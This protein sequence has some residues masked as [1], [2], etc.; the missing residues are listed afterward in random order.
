MGP[1]KGIKVVEIAGIGPAPVAGMLLADLGAEVILVER[2]TGNPNAISPAAARMGK[3]AFF[4]RGK[5][6]IALDLKMPEALELVL[7][8]V[9][10]ADVLIEGFRPGV[11]ERLG[12]GP[13]TCFEKNARLVYGRMTGWGQ[14]GP[15][16]QSAGHDLN[17]ASLSGALHY[18][19]LPGD[20]PFP[21]AT[22]LG[23]VAGGAMH[24]ALGVVSA[25]LH[26]QR[27]GEG[28]I[29]DAAVCDG[30]AYMMTLFAS[31]YAQGIIGDERG[32]DFFT[33]GAH[34]CNT[35]MCADQRY[36]T[37]EALEP[38]FYRQLISLC[39][40][41]DDPDFAEQHRKASWPAA[42][43]KMSRLFASK[44]Q[45]EWSSLLE[46]TDSCFAP[47]LNLNEA[48][49]HPHNRARNNFR[50]IDGSVQPM[51]APKFNKTPHEVG[52]IPAFGEHLREIL[53]EVDFPDN[54]ATV[55]LADQLT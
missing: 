11:M 43:E 31:V 7:A 1:L 16:A 26:A 53:E 30:S 38:N 44:T 15:L 5:R 51:P 50:K 24:L 54:K 35:Y 4:K 3:A 2:K 29:V 8:L 39:G 13:E 18:C 48:A 14:H 55:L 34:F 28:Q 49:E 32:E 21:P 33:G 6:S 23:D 37:V 27:S 22:V 9:A 12:L 52:S 10:E 45:A 36:I 42:K 47:V 25:I 41:G 19:G 40:F 46:G 17:Y 20:A